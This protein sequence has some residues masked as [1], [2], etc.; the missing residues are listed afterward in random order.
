[1]L[2]TYHTILFWLYWL[3]IAWLG[4][5]ALAAL[6]RESDRG[7]KATAAMLLVP[8]ILRILLVK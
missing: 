4:A 5:L 6:V 1:M 7:V 2:T 3:I 8:V